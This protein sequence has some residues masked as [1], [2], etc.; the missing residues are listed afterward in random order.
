MIRVVLIQKH[1][2]RLRRYVAYEARRAEDARNH[3]V[4]EARRAE[5]AILVV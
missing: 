3:I 2:T 5:Y 4:Y 1:N